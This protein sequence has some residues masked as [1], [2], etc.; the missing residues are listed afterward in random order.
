MSTHN[1][2]SQHK[3]CLLSW[4]K[5]GTDKAYKRDVY[6]NRV[7]PAPPVLSQGGSSASPEAAD[8][9]QSHTKVAMWESRLCHQ[10]FGTSGGSQK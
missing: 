1:S 6:R 10:T 7:C 3:T 5:D 9:P 8:A 2:N 4:R